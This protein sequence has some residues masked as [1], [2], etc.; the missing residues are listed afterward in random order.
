MSHYCH[1]H[2][3]QY[4][5]M[6]RTHQQD[7]AQAIADIEQ[8]IYTVSSLDEI[9][10]DVVDPAYG[11]LRQAD[12]G[13]PQ[14]SGSIDSGVQAM[15]FLGLAVFAR[16]AS[17]DAEFAK[18]LNKWVE[19]LSEA[20]N[21]AKAGFL[22]FDLATYTHADSDSLA[23]GFTG[24][25]IGVGMVVAGYHL[26]QWL[27]NQHENLSRRIA[28]NQQL[29]TRLN[30]QQCIVE[31]LTVNADSPAPQLYNRFKQFEKF[32][33]E[34]LAS[35]DEFEKIFADKPV[36][37]SRILAGFQGFGLKTAALTKSTLDSL[38]TGTTVWADYTL[39]SGVLQS[40]HVP[41]GGLNASVSGLLLGGVAAGATAL[42][43]GN[44]VRKQEQWKQDS[45]QYSEIELRLAI[46][47]LRVSL[48]QKKQEYLRALKVVLESADHFPYRNHLQTEFS[49][50]LSTSLPA[51][52]YCFPGQFARQREEYIE[53]RDQE[54]AALQSTRAGLQREECRL[55][56][57]INGFDMVKSVTRV[58]TVKN[59]TKVVQ[60]PL[61]VKLIMTTAIKTCAIHG[62]LM[63]ST[64][65]AVAG[66]GFFGIGAVPGAAVGGA[67]GAV[68]GA[69]FG[70][71]Y[72]LARLCVLAIAGYCVSKRLSQATEDRAKNEYE[73]FNTIN[74]Q[75]GAPAAACPRG[76]NT[77]RQQQSV[78]GWAAGRPV[79]RVVQSKPAHF[80]YN[81]FKTP[82]KPKP[83]L[84][85][86]S[87]RPI[88]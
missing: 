66:S 55:A 33:T 6:T 1:N 11:E 83:I 57:K 34:L 19:T 49:G 3:V 23:P 60:V 31:S 47:E 2:S 59:V 32:A 67:A 24:M 88:F 18:R 35:L 30:F 46:N 75:P 87:S 41:V 44:E 50:D 69:L 52:S 86:L 27:R 81:W 56:A 72:G 7:Q 8:K 40:S 20:K 16:T 78:T 22:T 36:D 28:S 84:V 54:Y 65:G 71:L 26:A 58:E 77:V 73:R 37:E 61:E 17:S 42:Y 5:P 12:S 53:K 48:H 43:S 39:S 70:L 51:L 80:R 14:Y 9:T 74:N 21:M 85:E 29:T 62:A 64:G 63:G 68:T 4:P 10:Q 13:L 38:Y 79:A 82:C 15:L 25:M 76:A 45:L